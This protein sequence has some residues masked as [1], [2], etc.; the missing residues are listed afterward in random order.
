[1]PQSVIGLI[2][3]W[4]QSNLEIFPPS[5]I[6]NVLVGT[7]LNPSGF[8]FY[9]VG[10]SKIEGDLEITGS[11]NATIQTLKV[12]EKN[13]N[14][15]YIIT[16]ITTTGDQIP[17]YSNTQITYNPSTGILTSPFVNSDLTNS[18]GYLTSNLVGLLQ[19]N[20][21]QNDSITIGTTEID[22]GNSSTIIAGLTSISSTDYIGGRE[23]ATLDL[24]PNIDYLIC[25]TDNSG[26]SK[27]LLARTGFTYNPSTDL[28]TVANITGNGSNLTNISN[29][30]I[31]DD[32]STNS[33]FR[34]VF[35]DASGSNKTLNIDSGL[36]AI[37][38]NPFADTLSVRFINGYCNGLNLST[39]SSTKSFCF[40][41][42]SGGHFVYSTSISDICWDNSNKRL[43]IGL[44]NPQYSIDC[45][46]TINADN[47]NTASV[48][49]NSSTHSSYTIDIGGWSGA[50]STTAHQIKASLNLHIDSATA[51]DLY[52]NYYSNMNVIIG[53]TGGNIGVG[54]TSP[55]YPLHITRVPSNNNPSSSAH[56]FLRNGNSLNGAAGGLGANQ[57]P[58]QIYC[59]GGS[60]LTDNGLYSISDRRIKQK[61]TKL[62]NN[63]LEDICKLNPV[64]YEYIDKYSRGE[65]I[66]WGFIAQEIKEIYPD[67]VKDNLENYIPSIFKLCKKIN[68]NFVFTEPHNIIK[69]TILRFDKENSKFCMIKCKKIDNYKIE[70]LECYESDCIIEQNEEVICYGEK[71]TN[72]QSLNEISL[73]S[74]CIKGIQELKKEND[75]LKNEI[76]LIK[77]HLKI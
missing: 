70:I 45:S 14:I 60:I 41:D 6:Y 75:N 68:N 13:D 35:T 16:F 69:N 59:Q 67:F 46:G 5:I 42:G 71:I 43:G 27:S 19:N 30:D 57:F 38:Y 58:V 32:T 49:C 50:S 62:N 63:T 8:K 40:V 3:Q 17:F 26:S 11:L 47:G 1:M 48:I 77:E 55:S 18:T 74:V 64:K 20:Q 22:L 73:I 44:S 15:D 29:I 61:I 24:Q 9:V 10:N 39:F 52:L 65:G 25:C 66:K 28:L 36:D 51:G 33:N 12:I 2:N 54:T 4:K 21:L 76:K 23:I 31:T 53:N 34:I 37:R 56:N 7:T 72:F